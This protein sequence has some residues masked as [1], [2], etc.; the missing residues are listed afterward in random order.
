MIEGIV[1][2]LM[3]YGSMVVSFMKLPQRL[4]RWILSH[5][6][7]T[8]LGAGV[9]V[10]LLLGAISKSIVAIVG[11]ITAGLLVGISLEAIGTHGNEPNSKRQA[12]TS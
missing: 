10:Y 8:D 1:L 3:T 6:L 11:A 5:K 2:G 9:I 12:T 7:L 4:R